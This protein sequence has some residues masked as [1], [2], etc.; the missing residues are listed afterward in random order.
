MNLHDIIRETRHQWHYL[1]QNI[2][3]IF[4]YIPTLWNNYDFDCSTTLYRIIRKKLS[5]VEPTLRYGHLL[6]GPRYAR[7]IHVAIQVLDRLIAEKYDDEELAPHT[8]KWGEAIMSS[9]P[10]DDGLDEDDDKKLYE[11]HITHPNV[12]TEEDEEQQKKEFLAAMTRAGERRQRDID[13]VFKHIARW[14]QRWWD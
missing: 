11:M 12:H 7:Q 2:K 4:D 8:E 14:H 1:W 3:R 9:T 10:I 6:N 13:W 5:R